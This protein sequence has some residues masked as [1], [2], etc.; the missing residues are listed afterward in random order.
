MMSSAERLATV[1]SW[2][3]AAPPM[4]LFNSDLYSPPAPGAPPPAVSA[5]ARTLYQNILKW[6]LDVGQHVGAH[7]RAGSNE[8]FL[9]VVQAAVRTN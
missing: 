8:D 4:I 3:L 7:G 6:K 9:K 1:R 5:T 2:M